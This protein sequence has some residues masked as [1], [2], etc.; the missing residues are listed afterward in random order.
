[1][2]STRH[3]TATTFIVFHNKVL[4]HFHRKLT[5][6]LPIG[7]HIEDNELPHEAALREIQEEVG[8]PVTLYNPDHTLHFRDT[9]QVI[10]PYRI[11]L[12]KV[13]EDHEHIDFIYFAT[14][15][16]NNLNPLATETPQSK[17]VSLD[18]FKTLKTYD[19][20]MCFAKEALRLLG[21]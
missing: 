21:K 6:W 10:R 9:P 1:M 7:G 2:R 11:I 12:E 19:N 18:E 14:S 15:K 3:Y 17:W 8:L 5:V 4:L 20:V 13:T 16:T